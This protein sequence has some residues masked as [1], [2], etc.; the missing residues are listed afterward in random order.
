MRCNRF[1]EISLVQIRSLVRQ[2]VGGSKLVC[3]ACSS[4]SSAF[5]SL[6][7]RVARPSHTRRAEQAVRAL[8]S[9]YAHCGASIFKLL[10][11]GY[12][13]IFLLV[14]P[15]LIAAAI[16]RKQVSSFLE[17]SSIVRVAQYFGP[18][19]IIFARHCRIVRSRQS[20]QAFHQKT[21]TQTAPCQSSKSIS[22]AS[23]ASVT[24]LGQLICRRRTS[25]SHSRDCSG[26]SRA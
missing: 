23:L 10:A 15:N 16:R 20:R 14:F 24:V 22:S 12:S 26:R 8:R 25:G 11:V 5:A 9:P 18:H 13:Q 7:S 17:R 3:Q 19:F 6:R 21:S 1:A 4:S 2:D